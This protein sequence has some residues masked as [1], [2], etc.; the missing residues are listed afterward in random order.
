MVI[1]PKAIYR[2]NPIKFQ[3]N[4]SQTSK[5][6]YAT[7]YG[8]TKSRIA[9]TILYNKGTSGSITIPDIKLYYRATTMKTDW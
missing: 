8:K 7:S 2:F 3:Y 9:K 4:S 6:Q 1:L 5:K